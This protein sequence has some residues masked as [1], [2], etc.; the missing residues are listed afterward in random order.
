MR[1]LIKFGLTLIIIL[2]LFSCNFLISNP[3]TRENPNDPEAQL[4]AFKAFAFNTD[5]VIT[6]W[7]W[8]NNYNSDETIEEIIILHS[9]DNYPS[10]LLPWSGESFSN[11]STQMYKWKGLDKKITHYFALHMKDRDGRWYSPL[12]AKASLPGEILSSTF[13]VID[14]FQVWTSSDPYVQSLNSSITIGNN[15]V[16]SCLVVEL[17]VPENIHVLSASIVTSSTMG[18]YTDKALTVS[19]VKSFWNTSSDITD[20]YFQLVDSSVD[21]YVVDDSHILPISSII[22]TENDITEVIRNAL[23][24]EPKQIVF[25]MAVVDSTNNVNI[26]G[27]SFITIEYITN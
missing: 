17:D 25:K 18:I 27:T 5:E 26:T 12:Y 13:G 1:L 15:A 3:H 8:N 10:V 9:K 2:S 4:S 6:T 19:A 23:L 22:D 24:Y 7:Q 21:S 11:N 16:F 14:S 20:G